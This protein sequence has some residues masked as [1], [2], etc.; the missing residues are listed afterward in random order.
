MDIHALPIL[1]VDNPSY[2]LR[3]LD[4]K[5]PNEPDVQLLDVDQ[6]SCPLP[7]PARSRR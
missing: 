2:R 4:P 3:L 6:A 1:F 7:S 5:F